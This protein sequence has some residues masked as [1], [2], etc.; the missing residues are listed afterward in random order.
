MTQEQVRAAAL[1]TYDRIT[2]QYSQFPPPVLTFG[3]DGSGAYFNH[4]R[5][6]VNINPGAWAGTANTEH[7]IETVVAH[8]LGHWHHS[9][10]DPVDWERAQQEKEDYYFGPAALI[11]DPRAYRRLSLE[12]YADHFARQHGGDGDPFDILRRQEMR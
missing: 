2:A 11:L 5:N 9:F 8:E 7:D 12:A 6:K 3:V 1:R 4:I 10:A